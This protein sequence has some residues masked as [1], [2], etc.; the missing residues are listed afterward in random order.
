MLFAETLDVALGNGMVRS[1][2]FVDGD[3]TAASISMSGKGTGTAQFTGDS[4]TQSQQGRQVNV[5]GVN[6][7]A[8]AIHV[9]GSAP[10]TRIKVRAAGGDGSVNIPAVS[11]DGPIGSIDARETVL[12]GPLT[13][14]GHIGSIR[15]LQALGATVTAPSIRSFGTRKLNVG[16]NI[17]GGE[18]IDSRISTSGDIGRVWV[19]SWMIRSE[20][21]AGIA[22]LPEAAPSFPTT[23]SPAPSGAADFVADPT[24]GKVTIRTSPVSGLQNSVI[25][26]ARLGIVNLGY[27]ITSSSGFFPRSV[28]AAQDIR[29]LNA[30]TGDE[31]PLVR[32]RLSKLNPAEISAQL[33]RVELRV[34]GSQ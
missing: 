20:V 34:F 19:D 28:V 14:G 24:I 23:P 8:S 12:S 1:V 15:L 33:V 2:S 30:W 13:A 7:A 32:L 25:A 3:G 4:L 26:A 11:A 10:G 21:F 9:V 17:I 31:G 18:V 27:I 22:A 29:R 5:S 16:G 6:V